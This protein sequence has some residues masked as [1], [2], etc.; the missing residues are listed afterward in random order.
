MENVYNEFTSNFDF[1]NHKNY[2][3]EKNQN[4]FENDGQLLVI[5]VNP[6]SGSQRGVKICDLSEKY[7]NENFTNFNIINFPKEKT[8]IIKSSD[9]DSTKN[10][11]LVVFNVVKLEELTQGNN[12]NA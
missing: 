2:L 6:K 1:E 7:R 12:F 10:F 9:F 5:F 11:S 8:K 4:D 3:P